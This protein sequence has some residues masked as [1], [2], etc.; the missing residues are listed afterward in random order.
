MR[1]TAA[2]KKQEN[3]LQVAA[4]QKLNIE[5]AHISELQRKDSSLRKFYDKQGQVFKPKRSKTSFVFEVCDDIL[6]KRC[7]FRSGQN[8]LQ[9]L[10]PRSLRPRVRN[11]INN[12]IIAANQGVKK[13]SPRISNDFFWPGIHS[14]VRRYVKANNIRRTIMPNTLR[15]ENNG[16]RKLSEPG[17]T[18]EHDRRWKCGGR[19]W[20]QLSNGS[21]SMRKQNDSN[22]SSWMA[23]G[24]ENRTPFPPASN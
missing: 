10:V 13:T 19:H 17:K 8:C 21:S 4:L 1:K 22:Y 15:E 14:E 24:P 20:I 6:Y 9:L 12:S 18:M 16:T 11:L 2:V 7:L 5:P 3:P 23:S